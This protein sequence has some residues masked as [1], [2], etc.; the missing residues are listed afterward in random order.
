MK[1]RNNICG[2]SLIE[3]MIVMVLI[4]LFLV[5]AAPSIRTYLENTKVRNVPES[6]AAGIQMAKLHAV[7]NNR[8]TEFVL[9]N[10]TAAGVFNTCTGNND[11][12]GWIVRE[13][14]PPVVQVET[15]TWGPGGHDWATVRAIAIDTQNAPA[16]A[17]T[18]NGVGQ[19]V[20]NTVGV[21]PIASVVSMAQINVD[22]TT[23]MAGVVPL[24]VEVGLA[25]GV[26]VCAPHL[27]ATNPADPKAC[28]GS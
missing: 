14:G 28:I 6:I 19:R 22:S 24:R 18:F 23:G 8:L 17:V 20:A 26:R 25:R 21:A 15:F 13:V 2:F 3:L 9:A 27:F 4:A 16:N 10:V 11:C 7:K 12:N 5:M 1:A